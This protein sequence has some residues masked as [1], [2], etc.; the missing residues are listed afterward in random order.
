MI[1][2]LTWILY[3]SVRKR[4]KGLHDPG[5]N[6]RMRLG[7]GFSSCSGL[8]R[9]RVYISASTSVKQVA[10]LEILILDISDSLLSYDKQL[11]KRLVPNP[12]SFH[13]VTDSS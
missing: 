10:V 12:H 1:N 3:E 6:R 8:L 4:K 2:S 11:A 5:G 13:S 9:V 7:L